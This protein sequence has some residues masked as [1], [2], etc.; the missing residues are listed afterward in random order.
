MKVEPGIDGI[1]LD[2]PEEGYQN[3]KWFVYQI[4]LDVESSI[5][6][7]AEL[8]FDDAFDTPLASRDRR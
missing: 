4:K 7:Q 8:G 6:K 5:R 3:Y 2:D 1:N